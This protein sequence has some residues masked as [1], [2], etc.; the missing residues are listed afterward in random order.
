MLSN[1]RIAQKFRTNAILFLLMMICLVPLI[2][3]AIRGRVSFQF[4]KFLEIYYLRGRIVAVDGIVDKRPFR[5]VKLVDLKFEVD[6][7]RP[8]LYLH[9]ED[10]V[11]VVDANEPQ[12]FVKLCDLLND[13]FVAGFASSVR[14]ALYLLQLLLK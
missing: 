3:F 9:R 6:E 8:E 13:H 1:L 2:S 12:S 11:E 4:L 5:K 7:N 10:I 14:G